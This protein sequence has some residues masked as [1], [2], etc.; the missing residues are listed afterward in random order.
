M[1]ERMQEPAQLGAGSTPYTARRWQAP[2]HCQAA[3]R[4]PAFG[5][6]ALSLNPRSGRFQLLDE[7]GRA[8]AAAEA[9][10]VR[11]YQEIPLRSALAQLINEHQLYAL[12]LTQLPAL[13]AP[14]AVH[15][16]PTQALLAQWL[17]PLAWPQPFRFLLQDQHLL[18]ELAAAPYWPGEQL[19]LFQSG[20]GVSVLGLGQAERAAQQ[21]A[22]AEALVTTL[23]RACWALAP[24]WPAASFSVCHSL[25]RGDVFLS[26]LWQA[27][28]DG[29]IEVERRCSQNEDG[30]WNA[31]APLDYQVPTVVGFR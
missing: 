30:S 19:R 1:S 18:I 8:L 12:R 10:R 5:P 25:V 29:A 27:Q 28:G 20:A 11:Q 2:V 3:P 4:Q 14:E 16:A 26:C 31:V 24:Q 21:M 23:A 15:T 9:Q 22:V 13:P 6:V 17:A 7:H